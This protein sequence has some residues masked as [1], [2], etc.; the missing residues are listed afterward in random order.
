MGI[1]SLPFFSTRFDTTGES[2]VLD[3]RKPNARRDAPSCGCAPDHIT[4]WRIFFIVLYLVP[5]PAVITGMYFT[6]FVSLS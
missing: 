3:Y 1:S 4:V 2:H 5:V 6:Y